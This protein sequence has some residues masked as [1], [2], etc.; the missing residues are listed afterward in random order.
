MTDME[1]KPVA[2]FS[3]WVLSYP[4]C[5]KS[6]CIYIKIPNSV[7]FRGSCFPIATHEGFLGSNTEYAGYYS[8]FSAYAL[9]V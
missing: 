5:F 6:G 1:S 9:V 8:V 4:S 7:P 3:P 2:R